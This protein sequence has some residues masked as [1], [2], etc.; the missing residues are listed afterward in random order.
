[1]V[2]SHVIDQLDERHQLSVRSALNKIETKYK[3][4][5]Y[6]VVLFGSCARQTQKYQSDVGLL[7][8]TRPDLPEESVRELKFGLS[9][10]DYTLP[11]V[12]GIV[13]RSEKLPMIRQFSENI[14]KEGLVIWEK[15]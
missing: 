3:D 11:E 4:D 13:S 9:P 10:N 1:M 7:L 15:N 6:R 8:Y 5:I 14:E 12:Q 2:A